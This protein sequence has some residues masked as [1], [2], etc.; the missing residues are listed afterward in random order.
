MSESTATNEKPLGSVPASGQI[1]EDEVTLLALWDVVWQQRFLVVG[2]TAV[3]A[4]G[5]VIA[6]LLLAPVYRSEAVL[7]PASNQDS[8]SISDRLGSFASLAGIRI[9]GSNDTATTLAVLRSRAFAQSFIRD[10]DLIK[11]FFPDKWDP[12]A[13]K[14]KGDTPEDHPTMFDAIKYFRDNVFSVQ[15]DA[16]DGLVTVAI[17]WR[18]PEIAA[19]WVNELVRRINDESRQRALSEA[20]Q[21]LGYLRDQLKQA[22]VVELQRAISQLIENEMNTE[23]LAKVREEYAFKVVDPGMVPTQRSRPHRT[24][25]VVVSTMLGGLAAVFVAFLRHSIRAQLRARSGAVE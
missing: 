24:L 1:S 19:S 7:A 21:N 15:E 10:F 18:D 5:S 13:N 12:A 22:T 17:E 20:Q 14:W 9:G 3:F 23:M 16:T 8:Q 4:I 25:I 2:I 11:V 6:A